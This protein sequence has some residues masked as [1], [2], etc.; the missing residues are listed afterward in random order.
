MCGRFYIDDET[1]REIQKLVRTTEDKI[2]R[3]IAE[4]G[5]NLPKDVHPG[6]F[7]P[8]LNRGIDGSALC[9]EWQKW[10][11]QG[12]KSDGTKEQRTPGK[13]GTLIFNARCETVRERPMFREHM[14]RH[15]I[16]VPA[17]GFY[18]WNRQKEKFTFTGKDRKVLFLAGIYRPTEQGK[19]FV[20]LTTGANVSMQDVHDR[21]PLILEEEEIEDWLYRS[22]Q[23]EKLLQKVPCELAGKTEYRQMGLFE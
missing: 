23:A 1:A 2:Q 11:F 5:L 12:W 18:E 22:D 8:V 15:R 6:E 19:S 16:I 4:V 9:C 14:L 10:G 17:S 3:A 21:M 7:A 13:R 20:I